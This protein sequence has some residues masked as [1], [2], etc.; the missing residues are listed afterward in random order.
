MPSHSNLTC[1]GTVDEAAGLFIA[2]E[3][4]CQSQILADSAAA[5]GLKKTFIGEEEASY[6]KKHGGTPAVLFT[7]FKPE[8]D[9]ILKETGGDFLQ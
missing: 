3:R 8:Y 4:V 1:G 2:L 7:Q 9:M 6:T 5:N